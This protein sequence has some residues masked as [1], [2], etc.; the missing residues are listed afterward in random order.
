MTDVV[1]RERKNETEGRTLKK[2]KGGLNA[3]GCGV[4]AGRQVGSGE[5]W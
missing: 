4:E 3:S 1:G 2:R 5:R